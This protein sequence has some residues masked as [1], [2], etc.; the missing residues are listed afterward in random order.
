MS[1]L[2]VN[3]LATSDLAPRELLRRRYASHFK[4][5]YQDNLMAIF[6]GLL[7]VAVFVFGIYK[8]EMTFARLWGG[9]GELGKIVVLMLPP[10]PESWAMTKVY[11]YAVLETLA[12]ALLGTLSAALAAFPLGFFGCSQHHLQQVDSIY[13]ETQF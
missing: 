11:L 5:F 2:T 9:L 4:P 6:I 10:N 13:G 1:D 7:A 8:L 12:I 3:P